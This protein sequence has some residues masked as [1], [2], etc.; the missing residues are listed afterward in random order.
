LFDL[1][2]NVVCI[3]CSIKNNFELEA[4]LLQ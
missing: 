1:L 3:P 4:S 2:K